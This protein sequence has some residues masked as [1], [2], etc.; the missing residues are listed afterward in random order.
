LLVAGYLFFENNEQ[1]ITINDQLFLRHLLHLF[2]VLDF[3]HKNLRGLEAGYVMLLNNNGSVTGYVAGDFFLALFV[4][5]T[6][7]PSHVNILT[8]GHIA[9]YDVKKCFHRGRD[10]RFVDASFV[11][12]LIDDVSFSHSDGV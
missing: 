11:C 1:P 5:E 7:K 2:A 3:V 8:S 9:L 12:N 4:D 10:I 6:S